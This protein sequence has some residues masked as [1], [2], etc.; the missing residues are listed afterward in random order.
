MDFKEFTAGK[1][2]DGRRFDRLLRIFLPELKLN[3]IYKIIR[4]G[5]VKIN[6][7][8][9]KP[10][11]HI[12][13]GDIIFIADFLLNHN[14]LNKESAISGEI[15]GES[16]NNRLPELKIIF[17]N[18]HLLI[19][20]KPYGISVHGSE[21]NNDC[22]AKAV[23]AYY[24]NNKKDV[25]SASLSF[26]PGPLHRLDR[27]TS[28]LLVFS[29]SLEGAKWFSSAIKNHTIQ[30]KYFGLAEGKLEK[31]E[32]WEDKL[33]DASATESGFHTVAEN[34]NGQKAITTATPLAWGKLENKDLTL[35]EYS[36]KTGRKHQIRAQSQIHN[37]PLAGDKAYGGHSYKGL[38][39]EYYLQAFCLILPQNNPLDLPSQIK[40][41]LSSDFLQVLQY[42]EIKNPGL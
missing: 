42:C 22:L 2:D 29:M 3:E 14:S 40:M 24:E 26:R 7:K 34:E 38:K 12:S 35:V 27:N 25:S 16:Q 33:A 6:Q 4:K 11:T 28:G 8:K 41:K 20:D 5:L 39:R 37:H 32:I 15:P 19:I 21:H 9:A 23:S 18:E 10:E 31:A 30:K 17:E 1:D 36:I 13:Q